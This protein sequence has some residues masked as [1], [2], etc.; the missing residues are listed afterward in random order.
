MPNLDLGRNA[1]KA[2]IKETPQTYYPPTVGAK[3]CSK[4]KLSDMLKDLAEFHD[5][6]AYSNENI[7]SSYEASAEGQGVHVDGVDPKNKGASCSCKA[8]KASSKRP[9]ST[10]MNPQPSHKTPPRILSRF[11][12]P[13]SSVY[14][15][16][17]ELGLIKPLPPTPLPQKLSSSHNPNAYCAFHQMP[18]HATNSCFRLRHTIQD[19]VDNGTIAVPDHRFGRRF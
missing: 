6:R 1:G 5:V 17:L 16:L 19:L 2:R 13:L 3:P 15:T 4:G 7:G 12:V 18:G 9:I 14:E 11:S 8:G 10:P